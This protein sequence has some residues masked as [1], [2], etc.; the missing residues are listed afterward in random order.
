M[1]KLVWIFLLLIGFSFSTSAQQSVY[2]TINIGT[3]VDAQLDDFTGLRPLGFLHAKKLEENLSQIYLGGYRSLEQANPT[4]QQVRAAGYTDAYIQENFPREGRNVAVIQITTLPQ[5][6]EINWSRY[7][8]AG[9]LMALLEDGLVKIVVGNY[10]D[11]QRARGPLQEI[12]QKGFSDAFVK[13]INTI[14]LH[15]LGAFETGNAIKKP[16]IPIQFEE[17]A[18]IM[19]SDNRRNDNPN[20]YNQS[21]YPESTTTNRPEWTRR[22]VE[23]RKSPPVSLPEIRIDVK[24]RSALELQKVLKAEGLYDSGLDGYYG[25]GTQSAYQ[26][27]LAQNYDYRK[28][29]TLAETMP[30]TNNSRGD[31]LQ[32]AINNLWSNPAGV[33]GYPSPLA[34]AYQAYVLFNQL[35]PD[36]NVNNLMNTAIKSAYLDTPPQMIPGFDYRAT[37]AYN[38]LT[39]LILHLYYIHAAPGINYT[40]PCWLAE[41]HP[42][43]VAAANANFMGQTLPM[44][45][46]NE[47]EDWQEINILAAIAKDLALTPVDPRVKAKSAAARSSILLT[48]QPLSPNLNAELE[49]WNNQLWQGASTWGNT[50][51]LHGRIVTTLKVTYFQAQVRLEDYFMNKDFRPAEATGLALA[52]L[53]TVVGNELERFVN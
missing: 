46:C 33:E 37:Y 41:R 20:E 10:T 34:Q 52:T 50:D 7:A 14:Y 38:D 44:Q 1:R 47:F 16:L 42:E 43:E 17:D 22:G 26:N 53:R 35:G 48:N 24:R 15:E 39:Q 8:E 25:K 3:F 11:T 5:S 36:N 49:A 23:I 21:A 29:Q 45:D 6:K 31:R 51:P 2:Y 18:P 9:N 13:V 12:R 28:Y 40:V 27:F 32:N 19:A 4:L 30:K